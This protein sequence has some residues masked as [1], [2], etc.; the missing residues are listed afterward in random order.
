MLYEVEKGTSF[1]R[2]LGF[3]T[4]YRFYA[5]PENERLRLSQYSH[6]LTPPPAPTATPVSLLRMHANALGAL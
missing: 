6:P 4:A 1:M 2:T 5:Y 3:A